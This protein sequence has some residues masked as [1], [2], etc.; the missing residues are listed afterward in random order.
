MTCPK[1]AGCGWQGRASDQFSLTLERTVGS[2]SELGAVGTRVLLG[3][4][5]EKAQTAG[6]H[7]GWASRLCPG[8]FLSMC[9][10]L[11][12]GSRGVAGKPGFNPP[13]PQ[14][15]QGATSCSLHTSAP[16]AWVELKTQG[17]KAIPTQADACRM[18]TQR[19]G[20]GWGSQ[21]VC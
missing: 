6:W 13:P 19:L 17:L 3:E 4:R 10:R 16:N 2:W 7:M 14:L 20:R 11:P 18:S 5:R 15:P 12:L 9:R 21:T 8:T 1:P